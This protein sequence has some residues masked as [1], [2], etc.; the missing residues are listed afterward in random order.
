M[1][2]HFKQLIYALADMIQLSCV[3]IYPIGETT[4][5]ADACE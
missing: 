4:L 5:P 2:V 1:F 3:G